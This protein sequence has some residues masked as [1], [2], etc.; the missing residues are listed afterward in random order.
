MHQVPAVTKK[1]KPCNAF[2]TFDLNMTLLRLL[3][4]SRSKT[5]SATLRKSADTGGRMKLNLG[6]GYNRRE[7]YINVD[8]Q[9]ACKP[10]QVVDLER[11]PWPYPDNSVN[12]IMMNHVLE[13]LG[14]DRDTFLG[15]I[16]ELYRVCE[17]DAA[18]HINVPHPRHDNF[19]GDPTH[20]R[21]VTPQVLQLF[22][23]RLNREWIARGGANSPLALY[24]DVDFELVSTK[25]VLD[26]AWQAKLSVNGVVDADRANE[27]A[28]KYNNVASEY[29]MVLRAVK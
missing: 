18:I 7:G 26:D 5:P 17:P 25:L 11:F 1:S 3:F 10:D 15:I 2:C 24:L 23:K 13:H 20:V 22:S 29:R 19:I 14:A 12:T 4:S 28:A 21:I 27:A 6:C 8:H 9:A 16:K